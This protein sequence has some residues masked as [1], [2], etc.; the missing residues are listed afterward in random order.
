MQ[1]LDDKTYHSF[2]GGSLIHPQWVLTAAHCIQ[3]DENET[4]MKPEEL[5]VALGSVF[6]NAK[7]AQIIR[8][9]KLMIHPKYLSSG[10]RNDIGVVKLAQAAKIGMH[11]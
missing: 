2:C 9:Q 5:F 1:L 7:G 6:R 10:G 3:L 11:F 4:A 8:A